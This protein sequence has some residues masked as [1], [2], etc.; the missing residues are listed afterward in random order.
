[1]PSLNGVRA[2]PRRFLSAITSQPAAF[3]AIGVAGFGAVVTIPHINPACAIVPQHTPEFPKDLDHRRNVRVRR[4]LKAKLPI[5]T[6][7]TA[8]QTDA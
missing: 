4:R 5:H 8:A 1:V 3:A 6:T 7:R 2:Q